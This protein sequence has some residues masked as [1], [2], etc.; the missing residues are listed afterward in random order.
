MKPQATDTIGE[1]LKVLLKEKG[2]NPNSAAQLTGISRS[3]WY[4]WVGEKQSIPQLDSLLQIMAT[5]PELNETWLLTGQGM[6]YIKQKVSQTPA[7]EFPSDESD[8][9]KS[10]RWIQTYLGLV[11]Q[12]EKVGVSEQSQLLPQV[13]R[14]VEE[15]L[16]DTDRIDAITDN[17]KRLIAQLEVK[18]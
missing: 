2:L 6:M 11:G 9:V 10:L 17:Y 3:N 12:F 1:R 8:P 5:W 7:P 16:E 18:K 14:L 13:L 15:I 4:Q